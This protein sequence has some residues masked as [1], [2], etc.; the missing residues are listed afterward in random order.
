[1]KKIYLLL[2][3]LV[4]MCAACY[5][6]ESLS[7]SHDSEFVFELP[8]GDHDYD[9]KIVDWFENSG[10]YVLYKYEDK[11]LYWANDSWLEGGGDV[12]G[13][14]GEISYASPDTNYVG[15]LV[16]MLDKLFVSHYPTE[17]LLYMPLRVFLCSC[18]WELEFDGIILDDNGNFIGYNY[19][20]NRIWFYEG[21]DNYMINGASAYMTDT[22]T[23]QDQLNFSQILNT[24]FLNRLLEKGQI[25]VPNEFYSYST[26]EDETLYGLALFEGGYLKQAA[27]ADRTVKENYRKADLRNY[28]ELICFPIDYLENGELE[29]IGS[30]DSAP[31]FS[32][33]FKRPEAAVVK[34]KYDIVVRALKDLGI[35]VEGIQNP[36][37][38]SY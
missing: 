9:N 15:E 7:P 6:E 34:Q 31:S 19:A 24:T 2:G 37:V 28:L 3:V 10:F 38:L 26:Y 25:Q 14:G 21:Y 27:S 30:Y 35:K 4:A 5:D 36:P 29:D 18:L 13:L 12:V 8:Q 32:G 17:L 1:M 16:D 33:L 23:R 20:Y 22:L 11:D